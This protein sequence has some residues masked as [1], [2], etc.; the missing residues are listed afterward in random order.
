MENGTYHPYNIPN[1][2]PQRDENYDINVIKGVKNYSKG[3]R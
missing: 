1:I 2:K 3:E